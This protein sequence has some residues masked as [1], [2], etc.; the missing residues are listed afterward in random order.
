MGLGE[1]ELLV[2]L[3]TTEISS[4]ICYGFIV[5]GSAWGRGFRKPVWS[6]EISGIAAVDVFEEGLCCLGSE[7]RVNSAGMFVIKYLSCKLPE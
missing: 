1:D 3:I 7:A 4:L 2:C 5:E 6:L